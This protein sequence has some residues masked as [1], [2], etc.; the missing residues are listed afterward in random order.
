MAHAIV[1]GAKKRKRRFSYRESGE[2]ILQHA[3]ENDG[4]IRNRLAAAFVGT[5]ANVRLGVEPK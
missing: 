4:M 5:D 3:G 2:R 1:E